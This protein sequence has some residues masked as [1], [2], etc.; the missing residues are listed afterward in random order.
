[1]TAALI[2]VCVA[3]LSTSATA[4]VGCLFGAV[5]VA[6]LNTP[7]SFVTAWAVGSELGHLDEPLFNL[8][9]LSAVLGAAIATPL[10]II[11][12]LLYLVPV[13]IAH[14]L[15]RSLAHEALDKV[16]HVVGTWAFC[17]GALCLGACMFLIRRPTF[18]PPPSI[19]P[20][21]LAV[22][23]MSV[24]FIVAAIG[25]VRLKRRRQWLGKVRNGAVVGWTVI[26]I[27]EP[28]ALIV[29]LRPLFDAKGAA[30]AMLARIVPGHPSGAYRTGD[31]LVP[32]ALI[33]TSALS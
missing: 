24:G 29:G 12:G 7:L 22:I 1:M 5:A 3:M 30:D 17:V 20:T 19:T 26:P 15:S 27:H 13:R 8:A 6:I 31:T 10:G 28:E 16:F 33:I 25:F 9:S 21:V 32:E 18:S 2:G 14:R 11:F 23:V 4:T